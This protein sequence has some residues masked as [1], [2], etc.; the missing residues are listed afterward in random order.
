MSD[1]KVVAGFNDHTAKIWDRDTGLLLHTLQGHADSI[2]SVAINGNKVVT[3]SSDRTVKIWDI[4]DGTL[5]HTLEGWYIDNG[6]I[7]VAISDDERV[8][9][10]SSGGNLALWNIDAGLRLF[11]GNLR[12]VR[13]VAISGNKVA[14]AC[15][16]SAWICNI[17]TGESLHTLEG[18]TSWVTSIAI[19]NDKLVTGSNDRTAKIW[20]IND[21]T[22]QH[23]LRDHAD[24][25]NSVAI[26]GNK[27]GT[28]SDD[29]TAKIWVSFV[30]FNAPDLNAPE[31]NDSNHALCWIKHCLLPMQANLIARAHAATQAGNVFIIT[32][33]TDGAH[34]WTTLPAYVRDY[35]IGPYSRF[36]WTG[37]LNIELSNI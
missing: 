10:G 28:G 6:I 31:F 26:S 13:S 30:G 18:H 16:N 24:Q 14:F 3:G 25:V 17:D 12:P 32:I 8:V 15:L 19:S 20:D 23:T 22:L 36:Y 5:Q 27:V 34:I 35:L 9:I 11:K 21:G 4:N 33:D 7:Q 37:R 1:D 29:H 2:W